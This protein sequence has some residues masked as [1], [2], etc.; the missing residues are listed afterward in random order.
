MKLAVVGSRA[1]NDVDLDW[2]LKTFEVDEIVSGGA[3]GVDS[4][5]ASWA[6]RHGVPTKVFLPDYSRFGRRAPLVR[7]ED[8]VAYA[9][10]VLAIWDGESRGTAYTVAAARRAGKPVH[11]HHVGR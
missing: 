11:I 10:E 1:I 7:N 9:D 3:R 4:L 6:A 2:I 8:I 5:A